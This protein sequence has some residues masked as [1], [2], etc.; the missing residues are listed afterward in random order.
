MRYSNRNAITVNIL[1]FILIL[2]LATSVRVY[3]KDNTA[4]DSVKNN[5]LTVDTWSMEFQINKLFQPKR[6]NGFT[7]YAKYQ[8]DLHD[9]VRL[10]FG[11]N[12]INLQSAD[13]IDLNNIGIILEDP[14][15]VD[16]NTRYNY[17]SQNYTISFQFVKYPYI[18]SNVLFY[19]GLGPEL[20][21]SKSVLK[22]NYYDFN[23][24]NPYYISN[25][26][27]LWSAGVAG[28]LGAE[29]F[30][31]QN[32]SLSAEYEIKTS[33]QWGTL[34]VVNRVAV[35]NPVSKAYSFHEVQTSHYPSDFK[36]SADNVEF[37]ISF[38]F[39]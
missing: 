5:S 7:M 35:Y 27:E 31:T 3:A 33:E 2:S 34:A 32:M 12:F 6:F 9:A 39:L 11:F 1:L 24:G 37:G 23:S 20:G 29:W 26:L 21:Y 8:N 14:T 17:N 16:L 25:S 22:N 30:F 4:E 18:N 13:I 10:G 19:F 36:F 28:F 38:Y 15:K